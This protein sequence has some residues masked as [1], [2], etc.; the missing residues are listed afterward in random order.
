MGKKQ[1][2]GHHTKSRLQVHIVW[3]TKYRYK[4]LKGDIQQRCRSLIVQTCDGLDIRIQKGV[5][6]SDHVHILL[7]YPPK[8]SISEIVK[9][10]K[11]RSGRLLLK[12]YSSLKR[13][14]WSGHL[15]GIGYGAWS[16][17]SQT[18]EQVKQY[19]EHHR[20]NLNEGALDNFVLE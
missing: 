14:Y 3:I 10:L 19:L 5:V 12:E 13:K 2:K 8:L 9:K 7:E 4:V 18:E 1:R 6:S 11:G 16:V 15:W 17:G 20:P